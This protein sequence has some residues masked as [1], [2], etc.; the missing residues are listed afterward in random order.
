ME[1]I[2]NNNKFANIYNNKINNILSENIMI[3]IIDKKQCRVCLKMKAIYRFRKQRGTCKLC[4]QVQSRERYKKSICRYCKIEFRPGVE[5]RYKF[6]TEKCRFMNKVLI[7]AA[8]GCWIWQRHIQSKVGGYGTFVPEGKRSG[9]AHRA[10]YRLFKGYLQ[11]DKVIAH[12]C[13]NTICVAPD[14]LMKITAFENHLDSVRKKRQWYQKKL[15]KEN[16]DASK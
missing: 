11:K 3:R 13:D 5:G 14:H 1:T 4:C 16:N 9:L 2:L 10:S 15:I 6:C 8:T 12:I 7:D